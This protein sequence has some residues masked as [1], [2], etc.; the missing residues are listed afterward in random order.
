MFISWESCETSGLSSWDI[1]LNPCNPHSISQ[2]ELWSQH[3][4]QNCRTMT[5]RSN[6]AHW[7]LSCQR[8]WKKGKMKLTDDLIIINFLSPQ[9]NKWSRAWLPLICTAFRCC[10][11]Y[12]TLVSSCNTLSNPRV[13]L[14]V[15]STPKRNK[16]VNIYIYESRPCAE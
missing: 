3:T 15:S 14:L 2:T 11:W 1:F 5:T 13:A 7:P 6:L 10:L 16:L 9:R 12:S 4:T 8:Q